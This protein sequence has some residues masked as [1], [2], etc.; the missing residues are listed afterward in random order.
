MAPI[1]LMMIDPHAALAN[2]KSDA[3]GRSEGATR[4]GSFSDDR[5]GCGGR[6][7]MPVVWST[8]GPMAIHHVA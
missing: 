5:H 2:G 6:V 3:C 7:R 1:Y 4:Q 8:D